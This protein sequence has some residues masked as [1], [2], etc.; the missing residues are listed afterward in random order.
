MTFD[1]EYVNFTKEEVE[2]I[3]KTYAIFETI[4]NHS[5]KDNTFR[6]KRKYMGFEKTPSGNT[7]PIVEDECDFYKFEVE[8][9]LTT[10]SIFLSAKT[11]V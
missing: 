11:Q 10:L 9:L 4:A 6:V 5:R 7:F 8:D 2:T 3:N 1:N